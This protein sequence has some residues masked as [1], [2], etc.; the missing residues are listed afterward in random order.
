MAF[1]GS[2]ARGFAAAWASK[3]GQKARWQPK[4][5]KPWAIRNFQH[6][7]HMSA[8][9]YSLIYYK[10]DNNW[11]LVFDMLKWLLAKIRLMF[12][13]SNDRTQ[14]IS[15][16]SFY[17]PF[18]AKK[19]WRCGSGTLLTCSCVLP[20]NETWVLWIHR[21]FYAIYRVPIVFAHRCLIHV[22][23]L[24]WQPETNCA[25]RISSKSLPNRKYGRAFQMRPQHSI[26]ETAW[27]IYIVFWCWEIHRR[28]RVDCCV[29]GS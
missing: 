8:Y 24:H 12:D 16:D 5:Q 15:N 14:M 2:K 1:T 11:C 6:Q 10:T 3:L 18:A 23:Q 9:G 17:L 28:I 4:K 21:Y 26:A 27:I 25:F 29:C 22:M 7:K 20:C 13:I 19:T